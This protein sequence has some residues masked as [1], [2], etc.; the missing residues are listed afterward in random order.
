MYYEGN[1]EKIMDKFKQMRKDL[2]GMSPAPLNKDMERYKSIG[3]CPKCP[4]H[5]TCAKNAKEQV[6]CLFGKSFMC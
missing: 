6:F 1:G 3:N 4:T 2:K 5:T